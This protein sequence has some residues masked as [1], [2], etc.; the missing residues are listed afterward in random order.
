MK[1][2]LITGANS[3]IGTSFEKYI[4]ENDVDFEI[5][6]LDLLNPKWVEFDFSPYDSIFHV[7]AIV[8]KNE[9][10]INPDLYFSVNRDLPVKLANMAKTQ[11]V[12]QFIFLSSMSVYGNQYKEISF[13]TKEIPT[14][15]YGK[16][17]MEAEKL[18]EKL[19]SN[20]FKVVFLRPPMVYGPNATGNYSR[21]SKLAKITAIFPKIENQRSMIYI[22]NLL[23]FVRKTI[24]LELEGLYFPQNS[25]YICTSEL[26]RTIREVNGKNTILLTIFNPFIRLL[27]NS[28][29]FNKL[30]G[31]LVY[32]KEMSNY[33]FDYQLVDYRDSIQMSEK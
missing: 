22:D 32:M 14:T 16:S 13:D 27:S 29:Q 17:K 18:L 11:G 3:Y 20:S 5:D 12:K 23:E 1:R 6:T 31:N 10:N 21:L 4:I 33:D 8:H 24:E 30:F 19:N 7:A 28:G 15:Y 9:K 26:V 25:E 2:V